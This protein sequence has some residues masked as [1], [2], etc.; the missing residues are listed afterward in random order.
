M[1]TDESLP[2]P[3]DPIDLPDPDVFGMWAEICAERGHPTLAGCHL[4]YDSLH[5]LQQWA[6]WAWRALDNLDLDLDWYFPNRSDE[7]RI[8]DRR[9][10]IEAVCDL[11]TAARLLDSTYDKFTDVFPT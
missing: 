7:R 3:P 10:M 6:D 1:T 9:M 5:E 2:N 11:K 8:E 4:A